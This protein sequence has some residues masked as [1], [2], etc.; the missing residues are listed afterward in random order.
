MIHN[1][2]SRNFE[3][4]GDIAVGALKSRSRGLGSRCGRAIELYAL[5]Q[6]TLLSLQ[7]LSYPEVKI[8]TGKL[9]RKLKLS[10]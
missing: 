1:K 3:R 6:N 9:S 4:S 7:C 5:R 2:K 8:G 10:G